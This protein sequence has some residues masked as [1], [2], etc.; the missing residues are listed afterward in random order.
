MTKVIDIEL[1]PESIDRGI[2]ILNGY[3]GWFKI[4]CRQ[5]R[6]EVAN[7]IA[8]SAQTGFSTAMGN[9]IIKGTWPKN[10]VDVVA[11]HENTVS[12]VIADG[13]DAVFIEFGAGVYHN[14]TVYASPHPWGDDFGYAIGMYPPA[15]SKGVRNAWNI[16]KDVVTRGTPAEMPMYKGLSKA[17][18]EMDDIIRKVFG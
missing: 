15:P 9:D 5:L 17:L 4:K 14:G 10:D 16:T 12:V 8:W 18:A 2:K 11:I 6:E 13:Q 3:I 7:R 1:T